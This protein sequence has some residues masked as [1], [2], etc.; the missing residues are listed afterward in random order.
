MPD[1]SATKMLKLQTQ[2]TIVSYHQANK[3][4]WQENCFWKMIPCTTE[5][6]SKCQCSHN[7]GLQVAIGTVKDTGKKPGLQ[8]DF[9]ILLSAH[10]CCSAGHICY[11][12]NNSCFHSAKISVITGYLLRSFLA[13][14]I[15]KMLDQFLKT[16]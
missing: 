4:R 9:N 10:F 3:P 12:R 11:H 14:A 7:A 8:F 2:L 16:N 5:M 15:S 1:S 13:R 6:G